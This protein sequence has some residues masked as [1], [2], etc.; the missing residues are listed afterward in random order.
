[1]PFEPGPDW[2]EGLDVELLE[3]IKVDGIAGTKENPDV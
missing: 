3:G 1:M 2:G